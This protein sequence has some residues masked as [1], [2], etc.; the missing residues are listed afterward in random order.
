ME[1]D[2]EKSKRDRRIDADG[3]CA[4]RKHHDSVGREL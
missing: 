3:A 1:E 4:V 2:Y